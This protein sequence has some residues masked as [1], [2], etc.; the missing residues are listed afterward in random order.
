MAKKKLTP[1]KVETAPNGYAL[2][3]NGQEY[4][5]FNT[6]EFFEGFVVHVGMEELEFM[7]KE[8]I[9][10][11]IETAVKW[12]DNGKLV[13]ELTKCQAKLERLETSYANLKKKL[14]RY[15]DDLEDLDDLD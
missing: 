1:I 12:K 5:Y 15:T 14:S 9:R 2:N 11:L 7:N 4:M 3:V 13:K 8:G 6:E 10:S